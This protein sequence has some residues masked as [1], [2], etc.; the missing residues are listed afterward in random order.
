MLSSSLCFC[1]VSA[2]YIN[3]FNERCVVF[4]RGVRVVSACCINV[5]YACFIPHVL[6]FQSIKI[7]LSLEKRILKNN[8]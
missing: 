1:D 5:F 3:V 6:F 8:G 7:I 4:E 2:C